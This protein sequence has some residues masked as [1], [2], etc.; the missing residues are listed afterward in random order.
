MKSKPSIV[1]FGTI[2]M[3]M[4]PS[5]KGMHLAEVK[6]YRPM[7]GGACANVAAAVSKF[8]VKSIF[9]GKTGKDYFGESLE[10]TLRGYGVDTS[11]MVFDKDYR[12]T[13]NFHAKPDGDIIEYLFYRNPGADMNLK[14]EE[15]RFDLL[16]MG[17][18]LH[19]DSLCLTAEPLRGTT[20]KVLEAARKRKMV[21]SFDF[22]Y[23]D[24]I[25]GSPCQA[26][27]EV[28]RIL[29]FVD[30]FKMNEPEYELMCGQE[31]AIGGLKGI[32]ESGPK[33]CIITKGKEG[34]ILYN[35]SSSIKISAMPVEVV[36]PIGCGDAF[37]SAFLCFIV[38]EGLSVGEVSEKELY[39]AGLFAD[40]AASL[41]AT[42]EG[43]MPAIPPYE[44]VMIEF[45]KRKGN[46]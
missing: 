27:K 1:S 25:W 9:I 13:M 18:V 42:K 29:P 45:L 39:E 12:T 44:K 22:N 23:R 43:A 4:F 24:I 8:G 41:T 17:E 36:D 34:S 6:E 33:V 40:T 32:L 31:A 7:P 30:V 46:K 5:Q 21:I 35:R 37:I 10:H 26:V 19:F 20:M 28:K 16:E 2:I 38:K 11:G 3:D 15:V 14:T